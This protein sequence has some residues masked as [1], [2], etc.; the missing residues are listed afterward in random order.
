[1]NDWRREAH[2]GMLHAKLEKGRSFTAGVTAIVASLGIAFWLVDYFESFHSQL[3]HII[4]TGRWGILGT[5]LDFLIQ[6][7]GFGMLI[8]VIILLY[9]L[10]CWFPL[11][12]LYTGYWAYLFAHLCSYTL[13][14]TICLCDC[15][16]DMSFCKPIL[17]AGKRS[18][19]RH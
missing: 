7:F 11:V 12:I 14:C 16:I 15:A 19:S 9:G 6:V 8:V 1:M 13:L 4:E 2:L 17:R 3:T 18:A 5:I 10:G